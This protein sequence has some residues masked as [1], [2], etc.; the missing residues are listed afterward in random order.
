MSLYKRGTV[1]WSRFEWRGQV[2]QRTTRCRAKKDAVQV[3][4]AWRTALAK[5]E[6]GIFDYAQSTTLTAFQ[7]RMLDYLPA[8]VSPRTLS[9]YKEHLGILCAYPQLGNARLHQIEPALVQGFIEDR[10]EHVMPATVNTYIRTLHRALALAAEWKLIAR[11]P[12]LKM[13]KG[14]RQREFIISE[15]LLAQFVER[16]SDGMKR[17]LPFLIDTG[18]RIS[19]ACNLTWQ[20]VSLDPKQGAGRGWVFVAKGKSK[21]AKRYVPLTARAAGVLTE[22]R[23]VA[24]PSTPFVFT[25]FDGR[26]RMGRN[27]V[28]EQFAGIRDALSLPWDC[29]LH[30]TRHT[31]CTRLG[32]SGCDAFTIQRLAGH[33]S[34]VISQRYVHPTPARLENAIALLESTKAST[35]GK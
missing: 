19:E 28:S 31:F 8:H 14:E 5:G 20:T 24:K 21:Y 26:R 15:E 11:A 10:L 17:L 13:L 35:D 22:C 23:K 1:W 32:E 33:S 27:W 25:S 29:V 2:L 3:E 30:S 7:Q 6:V 34:I 12:K 9:S 18:L 16:C 4:A